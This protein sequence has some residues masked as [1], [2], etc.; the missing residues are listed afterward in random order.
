M[1]V[2]QMGRFDLPLYMTAALCRPATFT[3]VTLVGS[4]SLLSSILKTVLSLEKR[5]LPGLRLI[6]LP[7]GQHR[8]NLPR[9]PVI[10]LFP[11]P[12]TTIWESAAFR[13]SVTI[14]P[15][16]TNPFSPGNVRQSVLL[17][18]QHTPPIKIKKSKYHNTSISTPQH[19]TYVKLTQHPQ[20]T[21]QYR[22]NRHITSPPIQPIHT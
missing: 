4:I 21:N 10:T 13:L 15:P 2:P 6:Y 7:R 8:P 14:H 18:L 11:P 3:E 9:V 5:T 22:N 12:K 17:F 16:F 20:T 1:T 19:P